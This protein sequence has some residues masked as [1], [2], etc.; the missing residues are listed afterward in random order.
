[1]HSTWKDLL[2]LSLIGSVSAATTA[3]AELLPEQ[4]EGIVQQA[5]C[6]GQTVD[7]ALKSVLKRHSQRDLGWRIFIEGNDIDVERAILINKGRQ[8][9]YRWRVDREGAV[10]PVSKKARQL[11]EH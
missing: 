4:A 1:M 6:N 3:A 2:I 8:T 5:D 9:R 7:E 11:C 10:T